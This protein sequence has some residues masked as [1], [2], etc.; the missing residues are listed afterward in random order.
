[1]I[2]K[3]NLF[4]YINARVVIFL[5]IRNCQSELRER[6]IGVEDSSLVILLFLI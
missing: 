4:Y 5:A 3:E 1:M 6:E 2:L